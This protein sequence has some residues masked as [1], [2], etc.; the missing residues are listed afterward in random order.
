[1]KTWTC[2]QYVEI[3]SQYIDLISRLNKSIY[4]DNKSARQNKILYLI[5]VI[6][7]RH[8][9]LVSRHIEL[10][11][12]QYKFLF[13]VPNSRDN[14]SIYQDNYVGYIKINISWQGA[15]GQ[16]KTGKTG[17]MAKKKSL[18]GKVREFENFI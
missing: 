8:I 13:T 11:S 7:S 18:Q 6:I 2:S 14:K 17:K 16:G 9:D 4:R 10:I 15:H 12:W 3:I 1:M 5:I